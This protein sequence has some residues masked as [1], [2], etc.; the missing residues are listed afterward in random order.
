[1]EIQKKQR[2][3]EFTELFWYSESELK[4]SVCMHLVVSEFLRPQEL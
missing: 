3:V 2:H 1:M 4:S